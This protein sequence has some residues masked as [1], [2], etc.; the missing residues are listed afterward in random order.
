MDEQIAAFGDNL[1]RARLG[2]GLTQ[3][4]LSDAAA[5]DRAAISRIECGERTPD[6]ATLLRMC[7]VLRLEASELLRDIGRRSSRRSERPVAQ[8]IAGD[9]PSLFGANLT[10]VRRR[11]GISQERLALDVKVDRAA[12]GVYENGGR[13]PNLRTILELSR[14]LGIEP[15]MLL[16]GIGLPIRG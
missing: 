1:R 9:P 6:L 12:I 13:A 4:Q 16:A 8:T 7:R 2:L 14:K 10:W 3:A 11:A 5:L 15:G